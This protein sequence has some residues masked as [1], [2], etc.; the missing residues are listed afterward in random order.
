[1]GREGTQKKPPAPPEAL[2]SLELVIGLEPTTCSLRM[3][4]KEFFVGSKKNFLV[5][6]TF[7]NKGFL[8]LR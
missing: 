2:I 8:P 4:V 5:Q 6:K 1:M 3:R 7:V